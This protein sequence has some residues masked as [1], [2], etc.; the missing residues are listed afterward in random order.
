VP[1]RRRAVTLLVAVSTGVSIVLLAGVSGAG[2]AFGMHGAG[3][4]AGAALRIHRARGRAGGRPDRPRQVGRVVVSVMAFAHRFHSAP[5]RRVR[6]ER[7]TASSIDSPRRLAAFSQCP[8]VGNDTSC[9]VLVT[10]TDSGTQVQSDPSQPPFDG[11]EDTL[12]GVQND[13]PNAIAS[14]PLSATTGKPLFGFDGDG[15]CTFLADPGC[16]FG[17]T[18]YEGPGTSF[19]NISADFTSGTVVFSP[20]LKPGQHT[21][22]SLEEA[23]ATVPPFDLDPGPPAPADHMV[24]LGDS[25]SAGEG[26]GGDSYKAGGGPGSYLTGTNTVGNECHRHLGAYGPQLDNDLA[27]GQLTFVAAAARLPPTWSTTTTTTAASRRSSTR[28][29]RR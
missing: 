4:R 25:Y 20:A 6:T 16:P 29:T 26:L 23:L 10:V 14:I 7:R 19:T 24:A 12:I 18:G 17:S 28:W 22:F 13:S 8:P 15:L 2:A 27:L 3:G 5:G 21:Y 11:V 9:G 1:V